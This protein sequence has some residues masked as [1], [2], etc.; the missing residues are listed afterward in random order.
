AA[1]ALLARLGEAASC[2]RRRLRVDG[3]EQVGEYQRALGLV[4][5]AE[6]LL[7]VAGS[8]LAGG[9]VQHVVA[10]LE[11][12]TEVETGGGETGV[13]RPPGHERAQPEGRR[14]RV[15]GGLEG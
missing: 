8:F 15:P 13:G 12:R 4:Q 11:R 2:L 9:Q 5:V 10:D 6:G 7:T 1:G 3:G 14:D